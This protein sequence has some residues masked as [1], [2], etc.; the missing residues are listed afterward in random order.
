[1]SIR[2]GIIG[3]GAIADFH[4]QSILSIPD[5][6]LV[7]GADAKPEYSEGFCK[8]YSIKSYTSVESMLASKEIDAVCIC[9]PSGL[10]AKYTIQAANAKIH[11][12]TEKPM[13]ISLADADAEIEAC[14]RNGVKLGVVSQ[15]RFSPN[16]RLIKEKIEQGKLGK[17]IT[18][19]VVMKYYRDQS[20]FAGSSWRGTLAMDGGGALMNQGI[21]GIDLLLFLVGKVRSVTAICKTM[22]H[23]IEVEDTACAMLEFENG[24]LGMI[25]GTT[26]IY[27]GIPR[28]LDVNGSTGSI[29]LIEESV[30]AWDIQGEEKPEGMIIG[31]PVKSG[32]SS[33]LNIEV[34]GHTLQTQ[35]FIK[36]I[37]ENR[38]P[39]VDGHESRKALE[40]VCAIYQSSKTKQTVYL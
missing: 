40:L 34:Y 28:R 4:A 7:G 25:Q 36:A 8:K 14:E 22:V 31:A 20:Y 38:K 16:I 35:D 32:A 13:A 21:H 6:I 10:H 33:P 3:C 23:Q 19:D 2:F 37:N 30:A 15:L 11:V 12:L 17:L 1:M 26:S 29:C 24:A 27:P 5:A 39:F 9:T 18:G